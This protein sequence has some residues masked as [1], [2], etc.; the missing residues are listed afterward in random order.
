MLRHRIKWAYS[1]VLLAIVSCL[2]SFETHCF[3]ADGR[4]IPMEG[5]CAAMGVETE[6]AFLWA[7]ALLFGLAVVVI[8]IRPPAGR[9]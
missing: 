8:L 5:R 4:R 7:A 3:D 9:G 6:P 2:Y 1:L